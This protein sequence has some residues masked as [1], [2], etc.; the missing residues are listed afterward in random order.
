LA[1]KSFMSISSP[2]RNMMYNSPAV[3]ERMMLLSRARRFSPKGPMMTPEMIIPN[4]W[5]SLSLSETIGTIKM[6]S[7]MT[8]N[9]RTGSVKGNDMS[10]IKLIGGYLGV[11]DTNS[12]SNH[13]SENTMGTPKIDNLLK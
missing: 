1:L 13:S 4:K 6:T 5:G 8:M 3:P 7:R 10:M 12:I 9:L 2:E 11:Q